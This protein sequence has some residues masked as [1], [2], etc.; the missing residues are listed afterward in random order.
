MLVGE[1][2]DGGL[3]TLKEDKNKFFYFRKHNLT[4]IEKDLKLSP[5]LSL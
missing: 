1:S 5:F 3:E 4:Y 2:T